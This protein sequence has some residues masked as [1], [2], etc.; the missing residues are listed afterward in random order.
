MNTYCPVC[1]FDL[2]FLSWEGDSPSD[3]ICP[4]C[5]IQYGYDDV[6][7]GDVKQRKEVYSKWRETWIKNGH[8][9]FSQNKQ[10]KDWNPV[11]QLER[12]I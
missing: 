8:S 10:P 4:S 3:E 6:A 7:G 2:G 9:W 12:V 11:K 5:G 1:G